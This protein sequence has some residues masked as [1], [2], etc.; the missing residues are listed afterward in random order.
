AQKLEKEFATER[1][2]YYR[3]VRRDDPKLVEALDRAH[4]LLATVR[5]DTAL[6]AA[7]RTQLIVTLKWDLDKLKEIAAERRRLSGRE[8]VIARSAREAV[9]KDSA[10]RRDESS[11][12]GVREADTIVERR[13]RALA[14]TRDY[15]GRAADRN[16]RV[17]RGVDDSAIPDGRNITF[18]K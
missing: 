17:M 4:A 10:A 2:A 1:A 15:R 11:K 14:D 5:A 16:T 18:P 8:D 12:A 7:R 9:R 13:A 6:K 3:L